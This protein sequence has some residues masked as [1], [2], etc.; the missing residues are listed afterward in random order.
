[1][2][3]AGCTHLQSGVF[4]FNLV[5]NNVLMRLIQGLS[6]FKKLNSFQ[7]VFLSVHVYPSVNL[8]L[9]IC[10]SFCMCVLFVCLCLS[11]CIYPSVFMSDCLYSYICLS[12]CPPTRLFV[13][14]PVCL[15]LSV[16]NIHETH[17]SHLDGNGME[18]PRDEL[19]PIL[20]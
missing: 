20:C 10:L 1:M 19:D 2:R 4:L 7:T 6:L 8:Y 11:I 5:A 12:V 13:C 17:Y 14:M 18:G 9:S 15:S 3:G 16:S